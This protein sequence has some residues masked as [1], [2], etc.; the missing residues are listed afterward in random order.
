MSTIT[1]SDERREALEKIASDAYV[2][3]DAFVAFCWNQHLEA[4]D[5]DT[6]T[7]AE[8]QDA[9]VGEYSD[10]AEF[11]RELAEDEGDDRNIPSHLWSAIDWEEVWQCHYRH[12]FYEID[13]HFFRSI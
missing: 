13:G 12:D 5:V 11:A 6:D 7:V 3:I 2:D 9:Y 1:M 8:F 10:E 4:D